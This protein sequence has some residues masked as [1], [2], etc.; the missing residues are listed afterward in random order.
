[1]SPTSCAQ[2]NAFFLKKKSTLGLCM[3]SGICACDVFRKI[4][5]KRRTNQPRRDGTA[6]GYGI[7]T[8]SRDPPRSRRERRTRPRL[9]VVTATDI[10]KGSRAMALRISELVNGLRPMGTGRY[11]FLPPNQT[12]AFGFP[13][14][15]TGPIFHNFPPF[16]LREHL[17]WSDEHQVEIN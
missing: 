8:S 2:D 7:I 10:G 13:S 15:V 6:D 12:K 11:A 17:S 16:P 9:V 14:E 4:G 3:Y 5:R 1:M